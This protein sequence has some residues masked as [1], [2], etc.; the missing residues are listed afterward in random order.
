MLQMQEVME[1]VVQQWPMIGKCVN[2]FFDNTIS[3]L[4]YLLP[5]MYRSFIRLD[6]SEVFKVDLPVVM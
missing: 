3:I 6:M 4:S 2:H 5:C 1:K